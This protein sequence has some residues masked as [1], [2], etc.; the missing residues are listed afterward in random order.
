MNEDT[1]DKEFREAQKRSWPFP[2]YSPVQTKSPQSP[3][4]AKSSTT[5]QKKWWAIGKNFRVFEH[6][7]GNFTAQASISGQFPDKLTA[8]RK[9]LSLL[10][11]ERTRL[12]ARIKR[13]DEAEEELR[14]VVEEEKK[15]QK[16]KA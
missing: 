12:R 5:P 7:Q 1:H 3:L 4:T 10:Q 14:V 9:S 8:A 15:A 6:F 2:C 16:A 13:L 11:S